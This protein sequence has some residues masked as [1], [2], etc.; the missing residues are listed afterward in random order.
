MQYNRDQNPNIILD[1]L[2]G[3][4]VRLPLIRFKIRGPESP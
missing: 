1:R 2:M 4:C 3:V